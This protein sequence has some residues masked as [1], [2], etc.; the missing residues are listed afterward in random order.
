[1]PN[2]SPA[3]PQIKRGTTISKPAFSTTS[4]RRT[5]RHFGRTKTFN[6]CDST[7]SY[8]SQPPSWHLSDDIDSLSTLLTGLRVQDV[9]ALESGGIAIHFVDG[10]HLTVR[11]KQEG[12]TVRFERAATHSTRAHEPSR[13]QREYLE[14]IVRYLARFGVSPAEQ[15]IQKHFMVS[16]PSVNQMLKTLERRGFIARL[17]DFTGQALPRSIRVLVD[18]R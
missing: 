18:L 9:V 11:P 17:R 6:F 3:L 4:V 2:H 15:D 13:R 7:R 1:M 5:H 12:F 8:G 16:A 14:F 10:T